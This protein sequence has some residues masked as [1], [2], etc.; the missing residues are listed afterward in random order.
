MWTTLG[1][2]LFL[3]MMNMGLPVWHCAG[4]PQFSQLHNNQ[5]RHFHILDSLKK[6]YNHKYEFFNR[7]LGYSHALLLYKSVTFPF[8]VPSSPFHGSS[9]WKRTG[10]VW[11]PLRRP[12]QHR[13][14]SHYIRMFFCSAAFQGSPESIFP[15]VPL[16][17]SGHQ[18]A[19][20]SH[21]AFGALPHRHSILTL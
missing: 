13:S 16:V 4:E 19:F 12:P 9:F 14:P 11:S 7:P 3:S 2:L 20:R 8:S 15:A 1:L 18:Q 6:I 21:G 17:F 5:T 10:E